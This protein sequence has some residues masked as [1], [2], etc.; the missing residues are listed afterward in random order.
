VTE[1][2]YHKTHSFA[3]R[4]AVSYDLNEEVDS[5]GPS[6]RTE[7]KIFQGARLSEKRPLHKNIFL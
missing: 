2:I 5:S 4:A 3:K 6:K 1:L 7:R